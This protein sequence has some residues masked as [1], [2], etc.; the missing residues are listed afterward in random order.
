MPE[1]R[2]PTI[3]APV[4]ERFATVDGIR[5][6][7]LH[8][9][10]GPV[11]VLIHGLMG[12]SF[13]WRL[14][15]SALVKQNTVVAVDL[16]GVGFS[17]RPRGMDASLEAAAERMLRFLELLGV[18]EYDLLGTSHGGALAMKMAALEAQRGGGT[19]RRLVLAAPANRWSRHGK[20]LSRLLGS[21]PSRALLPVLFP[22]LAPLLKTW[23]LRRQYGD[24][25]RIPPGTLDGYRAPFRLAGMTE[26]ALEVLRHL[27]RDLAQL[28]AEL[29]RIAGIPTLFL[30]GTRDPV[31]LPDSI[32]PLRRHFPQSELVM[33][34]GAGHLPYEELPEQFNRAVLGFLAKEAPRE[35][36]HVTIESG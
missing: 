25:R 30:W 31:V 8:G 16:P 29:P 14:N 35:A 33:L 23:F 12:Y 20:I 28:A 36:G 2:P 17:E 5:V 26:Y 10:S 21:G 7:Y 32:A 27:N 22:G 4:E 3:S 1:P 9:G 19:I 15:F 6:R 18:D 13:S 24:P 34:E 11:L